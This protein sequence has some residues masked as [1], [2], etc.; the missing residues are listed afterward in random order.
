M[1]TVAKTV[2]VEDHMESGIDVLSNTVRA[3]GA[4]LDKLSQKIDSRDEKI[5]AIS[6]RLDGVDKRFDRLD[7]R[8]DRLDQ[9]VDRLDSKMDSVSTQLTSAIRS[10]SE[11]IDRQWE[12]LNAHQ[13]EMKIMVEK[14]MESRGGDKR[15]WVLMAVVLL[16]TLA[17]VGVMA[18]GFKW[19]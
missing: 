15:W 9:K 11:R 17:V 1:A 12:S 8:V 5:G 4:K 6:S 10:L 2:E 19:I 3:I 7:Q 18:R 13:R 14:F 16:G